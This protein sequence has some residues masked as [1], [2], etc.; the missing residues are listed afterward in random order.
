M[1]SGRFIVIISKTLLDCATLEIFV[2]LTR[3]AQLQ[4]ELH[5]VSSRDSPGPKV[6]IVPETCLTRRHK[7]HSGLNISFLSV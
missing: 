1:G 6:S 5:L 3:T 7:N 4:S 2:R